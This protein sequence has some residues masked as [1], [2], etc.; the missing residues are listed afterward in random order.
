M[1]AVDEIHIMQTVGD[2]VIHYADVQFMNLVKFH[3][4]HNSDIVLVSLYG[5]YLS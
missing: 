3:I 1:V 5:L 2:G 4:C